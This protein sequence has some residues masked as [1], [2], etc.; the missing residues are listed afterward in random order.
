MD[1]TSFEGYPFHCRRPEVDLHREL[2]Q[3]LKATTVFLAVLGVT[4]IVI[5]TWIGHSPAGAL[6]EPL[7]AA[8][9]LTTCRPS[10]LERYDGG[11]H[12]DDET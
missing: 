7:S 4:A 1:W 11:D 5:A 2:M 12:V 9:W 6:F 3:S 8:A 10:I